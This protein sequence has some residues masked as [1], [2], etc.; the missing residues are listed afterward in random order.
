M[1]PR[2]QLFQIRGFFG[3]ISQHFNQPM[4]CYHFKSFPGV[5]STREAG[6][7]EPADGWFFT[8]INKNDEENERKVRA[9]P[10]FIDFQSG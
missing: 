3:I 7:W 9:T 10:V 5:P 6:A 4:Q 1:R 2:H 8:V